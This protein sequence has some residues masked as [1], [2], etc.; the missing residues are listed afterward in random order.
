MADMMA[1]IPPA[2][3]IIS[4]NIAD[5]S[6]ISA[7]E[8]LGEAKRRVKRHTVVEG[9]NPDKSTTTCLHFRISFVDIHRRQNHPR[10]ALI[11]HHLFI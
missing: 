9:E 7:W 1:F 3:T 2:F 6:K 11:D 8:L 4:W 5:G 10:S